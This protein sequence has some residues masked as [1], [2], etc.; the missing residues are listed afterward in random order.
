MAV[1]QLSSR[2]V[3]AISAAAATD[4][5]SQLKEGAILEG[6]VVAINPDDTLKLATRLGQLDIAPSLVAAAGG[7]AARTRQTLSEDLIG[8]TVRFEVAAQTANSSRLIVRLLNGDETALASAA[9]A[10]DTPE[11]AVTEINVKIAAEIAQAAAQQDGLAPVFSTAAAL[12]G[13]KAQLPDG[14][15]KALANLAGFAVTAED[16]AAPQTVRTAFL[17]SGLFLEAKLALLAAGGASI[18]PGHPLS[19]QDLKAALLTLK[20]LLDDWLAAQKGTSGQTA[21]NPPANPTGTATPAS[22]LQ[23]AAT[24]VLGDASSAG[25]ADAAVDTEALFAVLRPPPVAT[26]QGQAGA[27]LAAFTDAGALA[28]LGALMDASGLGASPSN[29]RGPYGGRPLAANYALRHTEDLPV[30]TGRPPPPRR[31][32]LPLGQA[33]VAVSSADTGPNRATDLARA[34]SGQVSNAIARISLGQFASLPDPTS[35]PQGA[36]TAAR[37]ETS[38]WL[39]E[40]P[41]M[42]ARGVSIAQ[43]EID[44]VHERMAGAEAAGPAWRVQFSLDVNELGPVHARLVLGG[45]QIAVGLWAEAPSGIATVSSLVPLLRRRLEEAGLTVAEIHFAAGRPLSGPPARAGGFVDRNA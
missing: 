28:Q 38:S 31:G 9:G 35:G 3:T 24:A 23:S 41:I 33:A 37:D 17:G 7:H 21:A 30:A 44:Q 26:A 42:V 8:T 29:R 45:Q 40:I 1:E 39:F 22:T 32:S 12:Q 2:T 18:D 16:L 27:A 19:G 4:M 43:F 5:L 6:R 11:T 13:L 15:A 34:L 14:L 20:P 36:S 25:K 10:Q